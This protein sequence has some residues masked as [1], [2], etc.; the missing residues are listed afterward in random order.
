MPVNSYG[1][2]DEHINLAL[3]NATKNFGLKIFIIDPMGV[4]ILDRRPKFGIPGPPTELMDM[5]P[6]SLALPG[7]DW[8]ITCGG[9]DVEHAR[10]MKFFDR[11]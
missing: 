7:V 1:F 3:L 10:A 11:T 4:D 6:T 9:D 2:R 8:W 5:Q